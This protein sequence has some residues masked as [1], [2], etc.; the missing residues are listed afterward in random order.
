M[1]QLYRGGVDERHV[2][3]RLPIDVGPVGASQV[4][5][6]PLPLFKGHP[7]VPPAHL[8]IVDPNQAAASAAYFERLFVALWLAR[9]QEPS[10]LD[11]DG[12]TGPLGQWV[13]RLEHGNRSPWSRHP[14][15][16][17]GVDTLRAPNKT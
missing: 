5:E 12:R 14:M 15:P 16:T 17:T 7:Q 3:D 13:K 1:P 10:D 11:Q 9:D 8:R 6:P 2:L 4:L